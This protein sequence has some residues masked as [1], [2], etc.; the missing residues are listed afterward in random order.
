MGLV[1]HPDNSTF[2]VVGCCGAYALYAYSDWIGFF[3]GLVLVFYIMAVLPQIL[4]AASAGSPGS[5]FGNALL[6]TCVLDVVSVVT[7]A[8]AFVPYGHL[9]RERTDLV[10]IFSMGCVMMGSAISQET[11]DCI[12]AQRSDLL[13]SHGGPSWRLRF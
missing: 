1:L 6:L 3:G 2:D 8:Y 11:I 12:C 5:T 7:A 10:L 4:R 13:Q 9:F